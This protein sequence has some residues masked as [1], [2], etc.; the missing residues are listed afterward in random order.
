MGVISLKKESGPPQTPPTGFVTLYFDGSTGKFIDDD[1]NIY[2]L[3]TGVSPEEVSD[4]VAD[5][6]DNSSE[7]EWIYDDVGDSLAAFLSATGVSGSTYGTASLVPQFAVNDK[8]R[9]TSVVNVQIAIASS[10]V[11]DFIEAAQDATAALID[12]SSELVWS[13]DDPGN[14]LTAALAVTG[15]SGSTY[16][17]AS[18]VPQFA[19]DSKG[20]LTSAANVPIA[21][22]SSQVTDFTEA[23]QDATAALI[24][25][26]SEL[27]WSYDDPGNSLTAALTASGVSGG[28]YGTASSVPQFAVNS[29]GRV[30]SVTNLPI[31][32]ASS[33]VTDFTEAAQDALGAMATNSASISFSY[34]DVANTFSASVIPGGVNHDALLNY[35]S[36]RHID[37]TAVTFSAGSGLT[38]GGDISSN[39]SFALA[40]SGV[41]PGTYGNGFVPQFT[42]DAF[43]RMTAASNGPALVL[44]DNFEE[45]STTTPVSNT[46]TTYQTVVTFNTASKQTGKYRLGVLIRFTPATNNNQMFFK[47]KID[48]V[49]VGP[50]ISLSYNQTAGNA[51]ANFFFYQTFVTQATHTISIEHRKGGGGGTLST[52]SVYVEMWRATP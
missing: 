6:I 10:Q 3:A 40:N 22:A 48:G 41:T 28:T 39:R 13:Y 52:N 49:D 32:V 37:H 17:T 45:F 15:V 29:K 26:S 2:T 14:S 12:D 51:P 16:G 11:T 38:G 25:D 31:A 9:L 44:G 21:I 20:R 33:Q 4:I 5:L 23:A 18:S 1:G 34:N 50:E 8:G 35:S 43:G 46:G 24:D 7:I 36:N 19:V 30:T 42:V 27:V 47:V